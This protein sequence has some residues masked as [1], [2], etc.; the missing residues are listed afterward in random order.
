MEIGEKLSKRR[1]TK[2]G[3][4]MEIYVKELKMLENQLLPKEVD[5]WWY[6][7]RIEPKRCKKLGEERTGGNNRRRISCELYRWI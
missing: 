6:V 5:D 3:G 1:K 2:I 7:V 4:F